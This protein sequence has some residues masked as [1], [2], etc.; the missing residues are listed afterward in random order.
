MKTR[1]WIILSSGLLILGSAGGFVAAV[2]T[3]D[4]TLRNL[5]HSLAIA[6]S[7]KETASY[8]RLLEG[9]RGG[10]S[11]VVTDRLEVML[12]QSLVQIGI[13]T[14]F[15]GL[16]QDVDE[17]VGKSLCLVRNYRALYPHRPSDDWSGKWYDAALALKI[18]NN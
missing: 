16:P 9:L 11:D 4:A 5:V 3:H 13:E 17:A 14:E 18:E 15:Y 10:K 2:K 7:A 8:T 6:Q 12:D 1:T